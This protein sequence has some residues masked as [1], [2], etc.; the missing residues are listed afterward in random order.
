VSNPLPYG[1]RS[2]ARTADLLLVRETF[3]LLPRFYCALWFFNNLGNLL[4]AIDPTSFIPAL[5]QV[6]WSPTL[7]AES[8]DDARGRLFVLPGSHYEDPE[9]SWK[10]A[11]APAAIGFAGTRLPRY[12]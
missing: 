12:F 8:Q 10:W 2:R 1:G 5:Q 11:V 4:S 7:I 6:R 9:F 3:L